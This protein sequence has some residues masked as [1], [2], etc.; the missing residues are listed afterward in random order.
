METNEKMMTGEESLKIITEMINKT[1]VNFSQSIF[2]LLLW[3]WLVLICS[4]SE[5]LLS[6]FTSYATPWYVWFLTIPG[7]FVSMIYGF[8][9]GRNSKF[10]TYGDMLNMWTWLGFL[11]T[12]I[13]L[14]ILLNKRLE[15]VAPFILMLAGFPTFL[16]GFI[17]RFRPLIF[18]GISMWIL[19]LVAGFGGHDIAPL[20]TP[21]AMITGYLVPGYLLRNKTG[22]G[23]I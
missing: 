12:M 8:V 20:A 10:H 3:G 6:R 19:A 14:F 4:L 2:H 9:K 22:H 18:G 17:I 13:I 1:K 11:A 7:I 21:L 5:F 23:T 16:T 15:S